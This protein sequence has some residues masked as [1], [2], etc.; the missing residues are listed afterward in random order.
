MVDQEFDALDLNKNEESL[1]DGKK[2]LNV[3]N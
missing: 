2:D 3:L 1:K